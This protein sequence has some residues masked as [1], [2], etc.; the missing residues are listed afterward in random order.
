[1]KKVFKYLQHYAI[2]SCMIVKKYFIEFKHYLSTIK[3]SMRV[4]HYIF[5]ILC[6]ILI[7]IMCVMEINQA[8][9]NIVFH[10]M[11]HNTS[12]SVVSKYEELKESHKKFMALSKEETF[13]IFAT[14]FQDWRYEMNGNFRDKKA[15]CVGAVYL[16]SREEGSNVVLENVPL[17]YRRL[18]SLAAIQRC[19]IRQNISEVKTHDIIILK[20]TE[21][22]WHIGIVYDITPDSDVIV[23]MDMNPFDKKP[24]LSKISWGDYKLQQGMVC[25]FALDFWVGNLWQEV[26]RY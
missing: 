15:D 25:E 12:S 24:T 18:Q 26:S 20:A 23:Y 19:S 22:N 14:M 11:K 8:R 1:M 2:L 9:S 21:T 5:I 7:F 10:V 16:F 4:L 17:M 13:Y 3:L 6:T